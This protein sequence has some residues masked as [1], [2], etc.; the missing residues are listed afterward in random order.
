MTFLSGLC[1]NTLFKKITL[2]TRN[3]HLVFKCLNWIVYRDEVPPLQPLTGKETG[4]EWELRGSGGLLIK[5]HL[6]LLS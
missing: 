1:M 5:I 6:Y 3:F 2:I 4:H